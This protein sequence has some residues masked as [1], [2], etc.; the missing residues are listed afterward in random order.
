M[1]IDRAKIEVINRDLTSKEGW[2]AFLKER[3]DRARELSSKKESRYVDLS[4]VLRRDPYTGEVYPKPT[5]YMCATAFVS[6]T[7]NDDEI[8]RQKDKYATQM[9]CVAVAGGAFASLYRSECWLTK[10]HDPSKPHIQPRLDPNR[11]EVIMFTVSH[12]DF[13]DTMFTAEIT[14]IPN[15]KPNKRPKRSVGVWDANPGTVIRGR[16]GSF[17]P[18]NSALIDEKMITIARQYLTIARDTGEH[19]LV[20]SHTPTAKEQS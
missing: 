2:E 3:C 13:G 5:L 18:P 14:T 7:E 17:V 9:R 11:I 12:R 19:Q 16:F 6:P 1:S 4:L 10:N 8:E 15:K 20:Y